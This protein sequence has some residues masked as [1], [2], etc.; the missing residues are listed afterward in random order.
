MKQ[1][2]PLITLWLI[3]GQGTANAQTLKEYVMNKQWQPYAITNNNDQTTKQTST[4]DYLMLSDSASFFS[5]QL[6]TEKTKAIGNWQITD[7]TLI[8]TYAPQTINLLADST[9]I[10]TQG[11]ESFIEHYNNGQ[12]IATIKNSGIETDRTTRTFQIKKAGNDTLILTDNELN[13]AFSTPVT[14]NQTQI[15]A[16]GNWN[17]SFETLFRGFLGIIVLIGIAFLFSTNKK[18]IQW[19]V[20]GIGL[21]IQIILAIG[22]LKVPAFAA[23][24]EVVGQ[25]FVLILDFTREGSVFLLGNLM[26]VESYGFIFAFQVLPTII[27]FSALTSL[28]FYLGIIQKIVYGLAWA[29]SKSMRLSGAESLSVAGNIF[30]GQTESPLLIKAYLNNMNRS[31]MLLVMSGGMATLAGG[32]LAAYVAFLGGD[33]PVMRL[34][35][36]KHLLAASVMAAPGV[37]VISKIIM[38]QTQDIDKTIEVSKEKIGSNALDAIS[39]GTTEGIKLAVN[40]AGMLLTFI[41]FIAL[42]NYALSWIG[43]LTHLNSVINTFDPQYDGLDLKF[44]LGYLFSPIVWLMGVPSEDITLVG[45][46]I[47]EKLIMTEFVAYVSLAD[48]KTV[49][50]AAIGSFSSQ[51]SILMSTYALCGFANI[52]SIGIQIGGIGTLAPNRRKTLSELGV[53]ALI[54]GSLASLLSATMVGM[55]TG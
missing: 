1:I 27:F 25:F 19:R 49:G 41:A 3:I 42:T 36:A 23:F 21:L 48:L 6:K 8:L 44:V 39:N 50:N 18:N 24:F 28:L 38:P 31:E 11:T 9:R 37:I 54:A 16:E 33:D 14:A 17:F 34:Y 51:K 5:F 53:R 10:V 29:M 7:S 2:L 32:V 43:D 52:A 22:I 13:F 4:D 55:I 40:V 47:G 46:L 30:L 15:N 35:F 12:L 20:V 45:R 26:N